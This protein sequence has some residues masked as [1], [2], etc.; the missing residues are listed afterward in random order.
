MSNNKK[1]LNKITQISM[2]AGLASSIG[3]VDKLISISLLPMLPGIKLGLANVI[4]LLGIIK[5]SFKESLILTLLKILIV[6]LLFGGLTSLFIG[7]TASLISYLVMVYLYKYLKSKINLVSV[8]IIGGFVHINIQL[9]II[10][11]LY[12]IGKEVYIYG[13]LLILI[14]LL[15]S[16]I[17]GLI[18]MKIKKYIPNNA[19]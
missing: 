16:T 18:V 11:I 2:L 15:T 7:G 6:C 17:I 14:S 12:K 19:Y 13:F 8:S 9:I 1:I 3:L 5:Y 4:I 10:S